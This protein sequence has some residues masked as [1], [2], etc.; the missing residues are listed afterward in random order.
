[1]GDIDSRSKRKTSF[2]IYQGSTRSITLASIS[3]QT[4]P[5][6]RLLG[7]ERVVTLQLRRQA[8]QLCA[9]KNDELIGY[10][11]PRPRYRTCNIAIH[12]AIRHVRSQLHFY[13]CIFK[14]NIYA[15]IESLRFVILLS[16]RLR[17]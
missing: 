14:N 2:R 4:R 3:I 17:F 10:K 16:Y 5:I 7:T 8:A 12:I 1:M 13:D 6:S 11:W 15:H 9:Q